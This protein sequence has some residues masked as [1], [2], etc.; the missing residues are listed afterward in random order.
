MTSTKARISPET[1]IFPLPGK[2]CGCEHVSST[3][4]KSEGPCKHKPRRSNLSTAF[5]DVESIAETFEAF[6][7]QCG[8]VFLNNPNLDYAGTLSEVDAE[9]LITQDKRLYVHCNYRALLSSKTTKA[10]NSV[11]QTLQTIEATPS[12]AVIHLGYEKDDG[13]LRLT[14]RINRLQTE[15]VIKSQHN[16]TAH[17]LLETS[18]GRTG[19]LGSSRTYLRK[20]V[21]AI[22]DTKNIG[23]CIDTAHI[24]AAGVT[25]A[26]THE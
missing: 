15:R 14:D 25:H 8:Q 13:F 22:D 26:S 7:L 16:Q 3:K 5:G 18:A 10:Y 9:Y 1:I 24:V 11:K 23:I 20:I 17:L 12:A 6:D 19:E 2:N 4:F 21:E